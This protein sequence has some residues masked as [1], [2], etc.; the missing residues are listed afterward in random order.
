MSAASHAVRLGLK[1]GWI[2]FSQSLK[3]SQDI[4]FNIFMAGGVL[5]YLFFN[6]NETIEGS[7]L[8]LPALVVPGILGGLVAFSLILGPAF[9]IAI[10]RE[11]GTLLRAKAIPHGMVGYV[12]GQVVL[13]T[14]GILPLFVIILLPSLFLFDGATP[15]DFAGWLTL[16]AVLAVGVLA[17]MP[18]GLMLGSVA[19]GPRGVSTW[20]MLPV[21]GLLV[22]SGVFYPITAM[23]GWLQVI[24]QI[25]PVY[26]LGLGMRSA[27]LPDE[28][29]AIE[30]GES[31]R[32]LETFGVLGV[33]AVIGLALAPI[34]LRRMARRESGSAVEARRQQA[35][36]RVG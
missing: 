6:R 23:A 8:L 11:D 26:W 35:L 18:W 27:F 7:D 21:I 25:F 9:Q 16:V 36:Q 2:E 17:T 15:G 29:A 14:L 30:I 31:W 19:R 5:L 12:I 22:I 34:V 33:W 24:A 1:R 20:G 10:E 28:A 13:H 32:T 3:A 4:G